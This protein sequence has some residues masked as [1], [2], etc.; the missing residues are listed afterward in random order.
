MRRIIFQVAVAGDE[1]AAHHLPIVDYSI[2]QVMCLYPRF[3][4][5][6]RIRTSTPSLSS[7][8]SLFPASLSSSEPK[9]ASKERRSKLTNLR[10]PTRTPTRPTTDAA[11]RIPKRHRAA[12]EHFQTHRL[13][14]PRLPH[15]HL[16]SFT[17]TPRREPAPA[18]AGVRHAGGAGAG[19]RVC[20][21]SRCEQYSI[22]TGCYEGGG[23]GLCEYEGEAGAFWWS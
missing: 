7:R 10:T 21:R 1:L 9:L 20:V 11:P 12:H 5:A 19:T 3:Q 6:H 22:W 4:F 2:F 15:R 13:P 14:V 17:P 18:H 16:F 23:H 8:L